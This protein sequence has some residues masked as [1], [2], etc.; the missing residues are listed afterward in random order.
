MT[1]VSHTHIASCGEPAKK[2]EKQNKKETKRKTQ[3]PASSRHRMLCHLQCHGGLVQTFF[4]QYPFPLPAP[5]QPPSFTV[6]CALVG[7]WGCCPPPLGVARAI[8]LGRIFKTNT[9]RRFF[10]SLFRLCFQF[11]FVLFGEGLIFNSS[12]TF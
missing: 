3:N 4:T 12:R 11:V 9:A 2:K 8:D 10:H 5:P 6:S 1:H 7:G